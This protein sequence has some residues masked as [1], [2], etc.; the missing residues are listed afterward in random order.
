[1]SAEAR[2]DPL[3]RLRARTSAKWTSYP[4]DVIPMFVAEMDYPLFPAVAEAMI[5]RIRASDTG[6]LGAAAQVAE[7][8]AGFAARR[9]DWSV[10]PDA[11]KLATDVSVGIVEALRVVIRPGD[12][13]VITPPVY[14]PFFDLVPES[15]GRVVEVPL[16]RGAGTAA[17][18]LDLDGIRDALRSGRARAVLLCSPHNP[19]GLVHPA[20]QLAA[21]AEIAA[22]FDAVVVSDEIHAPLTHPDAVFTPFL[23]VSDAAR[24]HGIA[25]HSASKAFNLAG[26]KASLIVAA[27][28]RPRA[29]LE[30]LP[31]EVHYRTSLLGAAATAAAFR[32]GDAWL[33]SIVAALVSN[34]MLLGHLLRE[35]L[36][37]AVLHEPHATFVAWV[38]LSDYGLGDDPSAALVESARVAFGSGPAF[39]PQGRGHIRVNYACAPET[40]AE[41]IDR[42]A[43]SVR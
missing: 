39:G 2:A 9:W 40:L 25:L 23:A 38:D 13:V 36:P 31:E 6:Y 33:D 24:E 42:T 7:P 4:A 19:L 26:V 17:W 14:P 3:E 37:Q 28:D 1:M 41:A 11:V 32:E 10:D 34:R 43:A 18:A 29:L 8:F 15:G 12:G 35:R 21:L 30:R 22:E 20:E 16:L 5:E 27:D